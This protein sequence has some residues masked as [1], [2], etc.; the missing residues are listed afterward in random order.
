MGTVVFPLADV[1]FFLMASVEARAQRRFKQMAEKGHQTLAQV[2]QDM[3]R[4]DSD[5]SER[6]LA[7][8]TPAKDAILI[9]STALSQQ[10]V[11]ETMLMH[12]ARVSKMV[13]TD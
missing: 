6:H 11:I 13:V 1:K 8:L 4:R 3:V 2:E 5:D 7:P 9:D 12:I 10:Q